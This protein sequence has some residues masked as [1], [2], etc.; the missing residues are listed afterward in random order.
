MAPEA[1]PSRTS[2]ASNQVHPTYT[3]PVSPKSPAT[4]SQGHHD[5]PA[6]DIFAPAG[7]K[8]L[9]VTTGTVQDVSLRDRWDPKLDRPATRGGLS[10]SIIGD[11]GVRY[12]GSHLQSVA[13]GVVPGA[14]VSTGQVIGGVGDSGN[15][16]GI[17]PHL[18]FGIS[19]PTYPGDWEIRRGVLDPFPYLEAWKAGRHH[20]PKRAIKKLEP[21]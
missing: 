18:H 4:Y 19:R 9:A 5:Y 15:A 6:V 12:Y 7:S 2:R 11:D 10:I 13:E 16:K 17:S 20:S 21:E 1:S 14:R 3:F 8:F